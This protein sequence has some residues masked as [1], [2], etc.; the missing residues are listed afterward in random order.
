MPPTH[1]QRRLEALYD[2]QLLDTQSEPELRM[3]VKHVA[4]RFDMPI[5][6]V[7]L[8]DEERQ[9][10][11]A[12]QGVE[13]EETSRAVSFCDHVVR[14]DQSMTVE[15][16]RLDER[17][18]HNPLVT[19]GL[20]IKSYVGAPLRT[21]SGFVLGALCMID[22]ART[23]QFSTDEV[24]LLEVFAK[25]VMSHFE[26]RHALAIAE[27]ERAHASQRPHKEER[28]STLAELA[29][30]LRQHVDEIQQDST[31]L[32]RRSSRDITTDLD[33]ISSSTSAI[34]LKLKQLNEH[35]HAQT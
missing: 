5:A 33:V 35:I 9:W 28:R 11:M 30:E 8:I 31:S 20:K 14:S 6:L 29:H 24:E 12:R 17:F 32:A 34:K 18:A 13:I 4:R 10:F 22:N 27:R 19:D 1:E 3:I 7:S 26:V 21:Q 15:D 25:C 2:Y 23:R 16:A